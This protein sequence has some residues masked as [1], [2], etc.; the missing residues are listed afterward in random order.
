ML[1]RTWWEPGFPTSRDLSPFYLGKDIPQRLQASDRL[2]A[3]KIVFGPVVQVMRKRIYGRVVRCVIP[4]LDQYPIAV[5]P[6]MTVLGHL[7]RSLHLQNPFGHL[8]ETAVR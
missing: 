6:V 5:L 7:K 1:G 8:N 4:P 2:M 3:H